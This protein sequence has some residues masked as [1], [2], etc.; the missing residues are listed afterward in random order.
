MFTFCSPVTGQR[1]M[2]RCSSWRACR[3]AGKLLTAVGTVS[4]VLLLLRHTDYQ[5]SS[6][7]SPAAPTRNAAI[8]TSPVFVATDVTPTIFG[9]DGLIRNCITG[10][11][12]GRMPNAETMRRK[13]VT[14]VEV[15][16]AANETARGM[17]R[18]ARFGRIFEKRAWGS[19]HDKSYQGISASG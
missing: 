1:T 19:G 12:I 9:E 3:L 4:V 17:E 11:V 7:E 18:R 8:L 15:Q 10:S 13:P 2:R 14:D 16:R 5:P 6:S